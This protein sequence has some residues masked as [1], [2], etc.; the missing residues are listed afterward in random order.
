MAYK[1][2]AVDDSFTIRKIVKKSLMEYNCEVLEAENGLEGLALAVKEKP[3]IIILDLTMPMMNGIEMLKK[4]KEE[5]DI[6]EIP[7]IMLTA[8]SGKDN[9]TKLVLMGISDYI[10]KPFK[11]ELLVERISKIIKLKKM[12]L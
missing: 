4:M 2:L 1:V 9:V 11:G 5:R 10:V 7:V 8:E 12:P 3:D 6:A